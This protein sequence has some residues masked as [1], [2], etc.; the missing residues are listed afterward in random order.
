MLFTGDMEAA[1]ETELGSNWEKLCP[2]KT[3]TVLKAAHHG[4]ATSSSEAL[5]RKL[6]PKY[7]VISAGKN[8]RYGHPSPEVTKRLEDHGAVLLQTAEH[9][10]VEIRVFK[11]CVRIYGFRNG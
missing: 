2:G 4:S 6:R 8:N 3:L 11:N 1:D 7:A 9:G 10:A 5:I